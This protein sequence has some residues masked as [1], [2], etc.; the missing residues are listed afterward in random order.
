MAGKQT[1]F[2]DSGLERDALLYV[3]NFMELESQDEDIEQIPAG[4][5]VSDYRPAQQPS[6]AAAVPV[7]ETP[8]EREVQDHVAVG[9]PAAHEARESAVHPAERGGRGWV[10][11]PRPC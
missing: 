6:I 7:A 5:S 4:R 10:S 9:H 11:R 3:S 1:A 2:V 8:S